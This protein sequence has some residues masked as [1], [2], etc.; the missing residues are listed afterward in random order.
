LGSGLPVAGFAVGIYGVVAFSAARRTQE[1][2]IR[3]ALGAQLSA[4]LRP[5]V[6]EGARLAALGVGIGIAGSFVITRL[7][8]SLLL[9]VSATDPVTFAVVAALLALVALLASYLPDLHE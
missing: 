6:G 3:M 8:S 4:I 2:G 9:G 1:I 5:V 7:L